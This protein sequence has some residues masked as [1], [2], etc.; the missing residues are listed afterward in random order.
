MEAK[1]VDYAEGIGDCEIASSA[2]AM[3]QSGIE[4]AIR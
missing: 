3:V 2:Q 1:I 4:I